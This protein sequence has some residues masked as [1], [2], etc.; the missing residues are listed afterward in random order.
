MRKLQNEGVFIM[1]KTIK[2][3]SKKQIEGITKAKIKDIFETSKNPNQVLLDNI[4]EFCFMQGDVLYFTGLRA[5]NPCIE[6]M[7]VNTLE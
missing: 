2:L 3:V 4:P 5:L 7:E 6:E 1:I